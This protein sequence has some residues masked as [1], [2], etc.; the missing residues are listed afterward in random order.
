MVTCDHFPQ[1][2]EGYLWEEGPNSFQ[3]RTRLGTSAACR[4]KSFAVLNHELHDDVG[5][6]RPI[7][8]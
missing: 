5:V 4:S 7:S 6:P 8:R 1:N 2:D 3:V